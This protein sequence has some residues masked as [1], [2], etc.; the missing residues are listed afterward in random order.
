MPTMTRLRV[1]V[2]GAGIGGIS[3]ARGLARAGHDVTVFERMP[4]LRSGGGAVTIWPN[5]ASVLDQ[6]GV[7]MTGAGQ[8]LSTVRVT[9]SSGRRVTTL[10][11]AA[12]S[13]ALG[14]PTRMVPRRT[15]FDRLLDG[16]PAE[17]IRCSSR[18]IAVREADGH[19]HVDFD[20]GN[21]AEGDVVIGADGR[22]S[23]VRTVAG[24]KQAE[25]TGWC[26][27]QGLLS[28]PEVAAS[29]DAAIIIGAH[30]NLGL[31]PAGGEYLQWWFDLPWSVDCARP[32]RPL[33]TIRSQF[34]GWSDASDRVLD[35]LTDEHLAPSPFPH[36]RHPIPRNWGHGHVTLL[37]D[38]AHV[39]PPTLAQGAN[40][41]LLDTLIL[42]RALSGENDV[43]RALRAYARA[44]RRKVAV[45]SRLT[46]LQMSHAE[47]TLRPAAIV[48]DSVMTWVLARLLRSVGHPAQTTLV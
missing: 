37:G 19:V 16:F 20:D 39:M 30:G 32:D 13:S 4:A 44:R 35:R 41:A 9:T 18:A 3:V 7:N 15:L 17:R 6:L 10:D 34:T 5:G 33:E 40:Q 28:L 36:F 22:H 1:L 12:I 38:S 26:S 31:W 47:S 14:A 45:V 11:L 25:P 27:W 48:P 23:I 43:P 24:A 46:G 8:E 29:R 42:C 2:I 21:S